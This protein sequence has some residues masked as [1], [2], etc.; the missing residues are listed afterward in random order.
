MEPI[1]Y[2][3]IEFELEFKIFNI[4][5]D[6]IRIKVRK[7]WFCTTPLGNIIAARALCLS[8]LSHNSIFKAVAE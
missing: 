4:K 7:S 5:F 3:I 6:R 2:H 1:L 8:R